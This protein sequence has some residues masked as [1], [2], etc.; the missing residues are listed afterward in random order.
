VY[1]DKAD[2]YE[3]YPARP[4]DAVI[5][6]DAILPGCPIDREEFVRVTKRLIQGRQAWLPDYP[7][8]VECK[9]KENACVFHRGKVCLGPVVRAGCGALCPTYGEGC[10]GCRG[11]TSNPNLSAMQDLLDE[12]GLTV[13]DIMARFTMFGTYQMMIERERQVEGEDDGDATG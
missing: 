13:D 8:C 7:V 12:A 3:T 4:I 10:E 11:F 2:W 1:G 6:V 9:L 5:N